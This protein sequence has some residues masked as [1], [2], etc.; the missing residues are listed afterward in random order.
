MKL[1]LKINSKT[2]LNAAIKES[3]IAQTEDTALTVLLTNT[4]SELRTL[5]MIKNPRTIEEA[6]SL[7]LNH[8]IIEQQLTLRQ[9]LGQ[10]AKPI[11]TTQVNNFRQP[12]NFIQN[13]QRNFF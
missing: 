3:L 11:Q 4:N 12:S 5:L 8:S 10:S 1:C 7:V 2:E 6:T 13:S 9:P